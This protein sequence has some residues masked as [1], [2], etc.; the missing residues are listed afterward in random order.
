MCERRRADVKS[1]AAD[2]GGHCAPTGKGRAAEAGTGGE[3]EEVGDG[4]W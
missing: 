4:R 2:A 3:E 1:R